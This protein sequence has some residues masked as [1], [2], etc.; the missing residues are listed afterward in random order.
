MADLQKLTITAFFQKEYDTSAIL[1]YQLYQTEHR[2][3]YMTY[4]IKCY[5]LVGDAAGQYKC[6]YDIYYITFLDILLLLTVIYCTLTDVIASNRMIQF[7][8]QHIVQ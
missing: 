5:E 7:L 1:Y 6:L 8:Y 4:A 3:E 2:E